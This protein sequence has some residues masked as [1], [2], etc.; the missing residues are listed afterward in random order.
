MLGKI[1]HVDHERFVVDVESSI[2]LA[3]HSCL[4]KSNCGGAV[5]RS[6][7]GRPDEG[8]QRTRR[9]SSSH[10]AAPQQTKYPSIIRGN[11]QWN[12][13]AQSMG[14]ESRSR[15]RDTLVPTV[16]ELKSHYKYRTLAF[17]CKKTGVQNAAD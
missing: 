4:R 2:L 7:L 17:Q 9:I 8:G 14:G 13:R 12:Q 1:L 16:G 6:Q 15:T 3:N 11:L 10:S 5:F